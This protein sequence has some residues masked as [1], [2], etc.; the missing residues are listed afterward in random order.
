MEARV[1]GGEE[2]HGACQGVPHVPHARV[3]SWGGLA[4][5]R[6]QTP[7]LSQGSWAI[8]DGERERCFR[9]SR[10]ERESEGGVGSN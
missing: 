7:S 1:S 5:H 3:S 9:G 2:R 6:R 4:L 10:L 8:F